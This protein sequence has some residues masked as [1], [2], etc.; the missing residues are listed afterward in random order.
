MNPQQRR[1]AR[2]A[3]RGGTAVSAVML[4]L[5]IVSVPGGTVAAAQNGGNVVV[6]S[7]PDAANVGVP[8]TSGGSATKFFLRVPA[9]AACSGDSASDGYR[10]HSYIVPASVNPES[11]TFDSS[12]PVPAGVGAALR[13][14][15]FATGEAY[16]N[17]NTAV[18]SP[19]G[20]GAIV[21]NPAFDFAVFGSDGPTVI[22]P[23]TYNLGIACANGD[24][25]PTQLDW[26]WN[27]QMTFVTDTSDSPSGI[28]WT[29]PSTTA[30]T[31][32][33]T[34]IAG[35]TTTTTIAGATTTTIAGATT[36]TVRSGS[37]TTTTTALGGATSTST[38][39]N[40]TLF[41]SGSGSGG[42]SRTIVAAG[43]SPIPVVVWGVLLLVFGRM[44]LLLGRPL[45]VLPPKPR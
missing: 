12:G 18:A 5:S 31:T 32:T 2:I 16:V 45:R 34:T 36:T 37:T 43:S 1:L 3:A 21:D 9:G 42:G 14:P 23:G 39:V 30:A 38:A 13:Q 7:G 19:A 29:T 41:G 27:V 17:G 6:L 10:V 8:I 4:M 44:A 20:T 24:P 28:R 40:T 11:L 15:L 26:Y 33:T 35:A 25:S 22:P